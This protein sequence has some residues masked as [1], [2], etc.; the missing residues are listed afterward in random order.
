MRFVREHT[1]THMARHT[2]ISDTEA[3]EKDAQTS[4]L[5]N[6]NLRRYKVFSAPDF[7]SLRI[8][9]GRSAS[10]QCC[11]PYVFHCNYA[12]IRNQYINVMKI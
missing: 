7:F 10:V 9:I 12:V 6:I 11:A 4:D 3:E 1:H 2:S 5:I 8:C